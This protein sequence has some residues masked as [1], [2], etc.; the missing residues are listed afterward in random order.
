MPRF[1]RHLDH[2]ADDHLADDV[3]QL[4]LAFQSGVALAAPM[5]MYFCRKYRFRPPSWVMA[6]AVQIEC[7]LLRGDPLGARGRSNGIVHRYRQDRIDYLRWDVVK[8]VRG[9]RNH[10]RQKIK[11]LSKLPGSAASKQRAYCEK[12]L[13]QA[14]NSYKCASLLLRGSAA[15]GG[16]DAIKVSF[17]K[18][19]RN[20]R[21]ELTA[22][23]YI[24]FDPQFLR[25][26]G[27]YVDSHRKSGKK[28]E[29]L[30]DLKP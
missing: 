30:F 16:V 13:R 19:A 6:A 1:E 8:E 4:E 23:R 18:V 10:L 22:I 9:Q 5:A 12:L 27:A 7:A 11:A 17:Q 2:L 24:G 15:F 3:E 21:D 28:I 25:S 26:V 29:D 14:R 20:R